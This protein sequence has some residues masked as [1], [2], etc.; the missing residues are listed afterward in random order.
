[1]KNED[2]R[3]ALIEL[4]KDDGTAPRAGF[5]TDLEHRLQSQPPVVGDY[6][7][8]R[9]VSTDLRP[10][11][12]VRR[13]APAFAALVLLL[14][15]AVY[16][17]SHDGGSG[18][19]SFGG[20]STSAP[21]TIDTRPTSSSVRIPNE[22]SPGP[23]PVT[24]PRSTETAAPDRSTS[25]T[26]ART[27]STSVSVTEPVREPTTAPATRPRDST[28]SSTRSTTTSIAVAPMTLGATRVG[29]TDQVSLEW[30]AVPAAARYI[31]VRT[32]STTASAPA[33]PVYP[34]EAPTQVVVEVAAPT[35]TAVN[36]APSPIVSARYRVVALD[37]ANRV[38][39]K[40]QVVQVSLPR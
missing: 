4:A 9:P 32:V 11:R 22:A 7:S 1:M 17:A 39:G 3:R 18:V 5:V 25:T 27:A 40:S 10:R 30:S 15:G 21:I 12:P 20:S 23:V 38:I 14:G 2:V 26:V 36:L 35:Q 19:T 24:E 16:A 6:T 29:V 34:A 37:A 13:M 31:V 28:T 33:E 8:A